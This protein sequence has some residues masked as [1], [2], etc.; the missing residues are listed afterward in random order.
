M[1]ELGH[2]LHLMLIVGSGM[3]QCTNVHLSEKKERGE[4][5]AVVI[6]SELGVFD[7]LKVDKTY[8]IPQLPR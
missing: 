2:L 3:N 5:K 4:P 1:F 8:T 7:N 6:G